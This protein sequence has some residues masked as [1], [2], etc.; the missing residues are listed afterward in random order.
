MRGHALLITA[1]GLAIVAFLSVRLLAERPVEQADPIPL[2]DV[3]DR[4]IEGTLGPRLGTIVE[5]SGR[6]VKNE[7]DAK[8]DASEPFFLRIDA[9]DGKN[10]DRSRVFAASSMRLRDEIPDLA[11]GDRFRCV[12]YETGHYGGLVDG[13]GDYVPLRADV[14]GFHFDVSF[15]VLK[16]LP[17]RPQSKLRAAKPQANLRF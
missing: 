5:V 9:V 3:H 8:A 10:L 16:P 4:G 7:S 13:E 15:V 12:G 14:V 6:V 1:G 11:V 2:N 17:V